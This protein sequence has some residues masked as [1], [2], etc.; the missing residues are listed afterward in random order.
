MLEKYNNYLMLMIY[1]LEEFRKGGKS[2]KNCLQ[3][4]LLSI[5]GTKKLEN[6][7]ASSSSTG[8]YF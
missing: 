8:A 5:Q 2:A 1:T 7:R 4:L 6:Y 3:T